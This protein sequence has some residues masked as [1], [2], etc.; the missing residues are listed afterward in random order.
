MHVIFAGLSKESGQNMGDHMKNSTSR[1]SSVDNPV[2]ITSILSCAGRARLIQSHLSARF[3][4]ELSGKS[5]YI[6]HCNSNYVQN[7]ELEINLI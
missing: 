5:N 3:Y 1:Q 4:F 6:I 7:F 2:N